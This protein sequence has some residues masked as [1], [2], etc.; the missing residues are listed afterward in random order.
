[1]DSASQLGDVRIGPG[2]VADAAELAA[3]AARTFEEAFAADNNPDDL[4]AHL[5]A[6][7]GPTQQAAE[8]ADSS[9]VTILARLGRELVGYS[10]VRRSTPPLCVDHE[11]PIELHRFYL[12][13]RVHGTGLASRLMRT[14]HS[15][16]EE[17]QGRHIWLGVWEQNHRAIAF[18]K[19]ELFVDVGTTYYMVG[20]DKQTDRVL[21]AELQRPILDVE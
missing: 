20:A 16:A 15:A 12:D 21:V 7:Y 3:F 10:Q 14:V 18:Y 8:L 9:V 11:A 19:K 17:L 2:S 6:T 4:R 1:M 13:S 5:A